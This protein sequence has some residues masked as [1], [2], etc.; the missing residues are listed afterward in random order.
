MKILITADLHYRGHWFRWL[1]EQ[2]G[3]YDLVFIAG[4][5]LDMFHRVPKIE[6]AREVTGWLREL[7]KVTRVAV[8]SGNHDDAG[9][10]VTI[11]RAPAYEWLVALGREPKVITDGA[12]DT[13]NDLARSRVV[14]SE[15]T[16]A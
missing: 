2:G 11:D 5:L 15:A 12:T 4:D 1:A 10:Q 3:N 7:A 14:A 8:S 9:R 16:R 13:V 6:Q